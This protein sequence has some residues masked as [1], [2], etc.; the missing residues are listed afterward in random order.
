M[1]LCLLWRFQQLSF[2]R[3]D[4][5]AI[6]CRDRILGQYRNGELADWLSERFAQREQRGLEIL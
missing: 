4:P 5:L 2:L 3:A 6:A 1:Q